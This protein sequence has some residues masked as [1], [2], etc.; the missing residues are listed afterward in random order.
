MLVELSGQSAAM[1]RHIFRGFA[2]FSRLLQSWLVEAE[3][4]GQLRPGLDFK[5]VAHFL[6]IALN[7]AA[8][9]YAASRD[10]ASWS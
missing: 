7:G 8:T 6:I 3:Q 4:R 9:L 5:E 1:S 10:K 2:G